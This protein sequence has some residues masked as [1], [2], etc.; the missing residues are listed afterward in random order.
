MAI[1]KALIDA[2]SPDDLSSSCGGTR[3]KEVTIEY[4][5]DPC[6]FFYKFEEFDVF[7]DYDIDERCALWPGRKAQGTCSTNQGGALP[8]EPG[9][10]VQGNHLT[11]FGRLLAVARAVGPAWSSNNLEGSFSLEFKRRPCWRGQSGD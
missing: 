8:C 2:K 6:G 4:L 11:T 9:R 10:K 7:D 3:V 5:E 1:F